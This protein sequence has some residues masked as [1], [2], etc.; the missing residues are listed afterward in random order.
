MDVDKQFIELTELQTKYGNYLNDKYKDLT[1]SLESFDNYSKQASY[2]AKN[3][4]SA[5]SKLSSVFISQEKQLNKLLDILNGIDEL[6]V[7]DKMTLHLSET[8]Y[9]YLVYDGKTHTLE[10]TIDHFIK[11]LQLY[12][13]INLNKVEYI[14]NFI[15]ENKDKLLK[16]ELFIEVVNDYNKLTLE[17]NTKIESLKDITLP[18]NYTF[19]LSKPFK[20]FSSSVKHNDEKIELE[21]PLELIIKIPFDNQVQLNKLY[22]YNHTNVLNKVECEKVLNKVLDLYS[23]F[24]TKYSK[25]ALTK[26][27]HWAAN[28]E[29]T[30]KYIV[31]MTDGGYDTSHHK[32]II[33]FL[34]Y[35]YAHLDAVLKANG[36]LEKIA[37]GIA[38]SAIAIVNESIHAGTE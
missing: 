38:H 22:K 24:K 5:I 7:N 10:E 4:R 27:D 37:D 30:I 28:I 15:L 13:S 34:E 11:C 3:V 21:D 1:G 17:L 19:E 18:G 33:K 26:A 31:F 29:K 23:S 36:Q 35:A 2:Y 8:Q 9:S 6:H 16:D 14:F 12:E 20:V 25:S 32:Q